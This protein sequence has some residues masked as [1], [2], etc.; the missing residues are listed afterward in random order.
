MSETNKMNLK[1][2][3]IKN[4]NESNTSKNSKKSTHQNDKKEI[5]TTKV[6]IYNF[7]DGELWKNK[8]KRLD[9]GDA[10][11]GY[12]EYEDNKQYDKG[13]G[14]VAWYAGSDGE[15]IDSHHTKIVKTKFFFKNKTIYKH[16]SIQDGCDII[17]IGDD[18]NLLK[19]IADTI[20]IKD[21]SSL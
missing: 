21:I 15:D 9:N 5:K 16:V 19:E 6:K 11:A 17:L 12:V 4:E 20:K 7:K 8:A 3:E 18:L 10:I 14:V 1:I 2:S 13:T